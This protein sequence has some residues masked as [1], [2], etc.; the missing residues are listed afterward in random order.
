[1][2]K[3]LH[4]YT[5][6]EKSKISTNL[7]IVSIILLHST[8]IVWHVLSISATVNFVT[9][10]CYCCKQEN[11]TYVTTFHCHFIQCSS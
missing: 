3:Q 5:D 1:M 10:Y 7:N 11:A 9:Y 2:P 6:N 4:L 8:I